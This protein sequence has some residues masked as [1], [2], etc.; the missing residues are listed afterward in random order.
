MKR[1]RDRTFLDKLRHRIDRV[2]PDELQNYLQRLAQEK[3]FLE[4]IFNS[5]QEGI[6]VLNSEAVIIYANHSVER[7]LGIPVEESVGQPMGKYLR[8]LDWA[9]LLRGGKIVSR[10]LEVTYPENRYLNFNLVPLETEHDGPQSHV[11]LF[12]DLTATRE[13]TRETVE[14]ERL[15]ALTLLAAG[16]AHELGN[17]LNSINIHFQLMERDLRKVDGTIGTRV[18]ES[19]DIVRGEIAR[20]D[21]IINQ[22]LRAVR[23]TAPNLQPE[24]INEIL[25][26]A[27]QF[28]QPEIQDRDMIVETEFTAGLPLLSVDRDRLKQAFYNLIKNAVQAMPTGGILRVITELSDTHVI[29]IFADN[30]EGIAPENL[31]RMNEPYFTTKPT[32]TGL[33][34]LIVRRIVQEHRGELQLESEQGR[35]TTVRLLLPRDAP[36]MRMLPS[37]GGA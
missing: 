23:P 37:G 3:G 36:S 25:R 1:S 10:D 30:G 20:L 33:G 24:Q 12:Y 22:F 11:L 26:E 5:L 35:G 29:V 6:V 16:V 13:Q 34:L 31:N 21:L 9:A 27:V 7:L 14:S 28:L 19:V 2:N 18:R 32:G 8:T 15:N 17:P 4:T